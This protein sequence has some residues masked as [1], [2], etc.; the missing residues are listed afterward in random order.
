MSPE[1]VRFQPATTDNVY[2]LLSLEE[3]R[4]EGIIAEE[5][6]GC[7]GMSEGGVTYISDDEHTF[8]IASLLMLTETNSGHS[9]R[10]QSYN[11]EINSSTDS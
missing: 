10:V 11:I 5:L 8:Q 7:K 9:L 2:L 1:C 6:S 4:S 3:M